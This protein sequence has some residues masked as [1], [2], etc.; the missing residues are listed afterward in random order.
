METEAWRLG[1]LLLLE[2]TPL[3]HMGGSTCT[4]ESGRLGGFE[5]MKSVSL[6]GVGV[7][8]EM[9]SIFALWAVSS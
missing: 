2:V 7:L 8:G 5:H 4:T 6:S 1:I 3:V 9:A